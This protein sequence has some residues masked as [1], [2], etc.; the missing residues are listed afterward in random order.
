LE[1]VHRQIESTITGTGLALIN[2]LNV[3]GLAIDCEGDPIA[4]AFSRIARPEH[5]DIQRYDKVTVQIPPATSSNPNLNIIVG[6][7]HTSITTT[8]LEDVTTSATS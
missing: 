2:D 1:E 8:P 7:S 4:T 5:G 6:E 3:S